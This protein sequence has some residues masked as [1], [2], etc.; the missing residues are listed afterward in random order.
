MNTRK[1]CDCRDLE[2]YRDRCQDLED[3]RRRD[4]EKWAEKRRQRDRRREESRREADDWPEAFAKQLSLL[5][6]ELAQA[7]EDSDRAFWEREIGTVKRAAELYDAGL[8]RIERIKEK[9]LARVAA[10]LDQEFPNND[11]ASA[12]RDGNPNTLLYW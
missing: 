10:Q 4:E 5:N 9:L 6:R 3:Q 7:E 12:L 1:D 2:Y 11:T 8:R